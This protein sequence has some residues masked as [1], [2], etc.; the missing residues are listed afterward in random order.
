MK[1]LQKY[2]C[3]IKP[4]HFFYLTF[5]NYLKQSQYLGIYWVGQNRMSQNTLKSHRKFGMR[6]RRSQEIKKKN[7]TLGFSLFLKTV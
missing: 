4:L 2:V 6:F 1:I 3:L 7:A 5:P